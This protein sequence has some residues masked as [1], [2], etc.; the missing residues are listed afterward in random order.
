MPGSGCHPSRRIHRNAGIVGD[1]IPAALQPGNPQRC[2][3]R[4]RRWQPSLRRV[5]DDEAGFGQSVAEV[6]QGLRALFL[7]LEPF[8]CPDLSVCFRGKRDQQS[9]LILVPSA[10]TPCSASSRSA[11]AR[12]RSR[13][14]NRG[15]LWPAA[16]WALLRARLASHPAG[17][18]A[19]FGLSE[20]AGLWANCG[21]FSSI[22]GVAGW[23]RHRLPEYGPRAGRGGRHPDGR[24][25]R[26]GRLGRPGSVPSRPVMTRRTVRR[27]PRMVG[28]PLRIVGTEAILSNAA[29]GFDPAG[30]AWISLA[31]ADGTGQRAVAAASFTGDFV[32]TLS[33]KSAILSDMEEFMPSAQARTT[34][35]DL[36]LSI[37]AKARLSAAAEAKHQSVSQFV[38]ES[39]LGRADEALAGRHRFSLDGERWAAFMAALDAPP[40]NLPRLERLFRERTPFDAAE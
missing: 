1:L 18:G 35:L 31:L 26:G 30:S 19:A 2:Q 3:R 27:M 13:I 7:N 8:K 16:I 34:K 24:R 23:M 39:A 14:G 5:H 10:V 38:L 6:S 37:D 28:W 25:W 4:P 29:M 21:A 20:M 15:T 32:V 36:R 11:D 33:G 12:S 40:R 17:G 22:A 9:A